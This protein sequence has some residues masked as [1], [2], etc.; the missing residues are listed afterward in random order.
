MIRLFIAALF[1]VVEVWKLPK[2][3]LI[4]EWIS[5]SWHILNGSTKEG[6][7]S[8]YFDVEMFQDTL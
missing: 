3:A 1:V 4:V 6:G 8:Q 5:K 2:C 7:R